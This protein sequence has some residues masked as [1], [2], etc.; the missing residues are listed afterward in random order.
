MLPDMSATPFRATCLLLFV[1]SLGAD[2]FPTSAGIDGG[3]VGLGSPSLEVTVDGVH[4][5]PAPATSAAFADLTI[6]RDAGGRVVSTDLTIHPVAANASCD[7][8]FNRFGTSVLP[9]AAGA[10]PLQ[11]PVGASTAD[12][13][14]APVGALTVVAGNL[15]L[16]C[17]GSDCNGSV[18]SI[19]VLDAAHIEGYLSGTLADPSDGQASS[20]VCT[21]YVPWR[22]YSP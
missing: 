15:T 18:L 7:L 4:V 5:G 3:Y 17:F 2:C 20:A 8:H 12:G 16:Q 22:T 11:A 14:S 19:S 10:T 1:G 9:F 21:F 6:T 13:T